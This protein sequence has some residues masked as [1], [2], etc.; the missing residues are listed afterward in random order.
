VTRPHLVVDCSMAHTVWWHGPRRFNL[1]PFVARFVVVEPEVVLAELI[2]FALSTKQ[3]S[4]AAVDGCHCVTPSSCWAN[5]L[6]HRCLLAAACKDN[7]DKNVNKDTLPQHR[8]S[9]FLSLLGCWLAGRCSLA[10]WLSV[11]WVNP[12]ANHV[13]SSALTWPCSSQKRR[14]F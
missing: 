2:P 8:T 6:G 13:G 1:M 4:L 14:G 11:P 5:Q 10:A 9:S 7:H 3:H 12:D